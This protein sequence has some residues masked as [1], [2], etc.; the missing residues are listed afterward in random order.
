MLRHG[1][2][3]FFNVE[4]GQV[5]DMI[6]RNLVGGWPNNSRTQEWEVA[7]LGHGYTICNLG[8]GLYLS[9]V[10][11]RNTAPIIPTHFPVAWDFRMVQVPD[12][13]EPCFE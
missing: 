8:T 4:S 11:I 13:H 2:Y 3:M 9:V 12:Q 7:P 6:G 5:A 10:V 1:V